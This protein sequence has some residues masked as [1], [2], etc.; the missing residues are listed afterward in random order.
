MNKIWFVTGSS[1]GLGRTLVEAILAAGD[2][3]V[4]TARKPDSMGVLLDLP[5]GWHY[6][7]GFNAIK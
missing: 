3:V 5:V 2:K 6:S 7:G 1:R 4:A